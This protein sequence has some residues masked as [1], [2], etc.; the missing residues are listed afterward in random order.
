MKSLAVLALSFLTAAGAWAQISPEQAK[1]RFTIAEQRIL[2]AVLADPQEAQAF[3]ADAAAVAS[4]QATHEF[5]TLWRAKLAAYSTGYLGRVPATNPAGKT[6]RQMVEPGEWNYLMTALRLTD[7]TSYKERFIRD[8][9]IDMIETSNQKLSLGDNSKALSFLDRARAT[10][11]DHLTDF[12]ATEPAKSAL[13]DAPRIQAQRESFAR[14]QR[15]AEQAERIRQEQ[16]RA[17]QAAKPE[18]A[19]Q[20]ADHGYDAAPGR[21]PETVV[22]VPTQPETAPRPNLI[23]PSAPKPEEAKKP[24]VPSPAV[25]AENDDEAELSKMKGKT[26]GLWGFIARIAAGVVVGA[27][28]GGLVG[29]GVGAVIGAIGGGVLVYKRVTA[30][31]APSRKDA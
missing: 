8:Q 24:E 1:T 2:A 3:Q 21:K 27:L 12:L 31:S 22:K 11:K 7:E 5:M 17:A 15:A 23:G 18:D 19:R 28:V 6:V 26:G 9:V 4:P 30:S 25:A 13:R 29:G 20:D 10:M 14:A 16:E